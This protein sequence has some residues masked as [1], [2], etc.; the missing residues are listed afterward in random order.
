MLYAPWD[1]RCKLFRSSFL[2]VAGLFKEINEIKFIAV[3][4]NYYKG[5]C[6]S[7]YKL[8]AFP[9]IFAQTQ[10]NQPIIFNQFLS[11][12]RLYRFF[13][14]KFFYFKIETRPIARIFSRGG[15]RGKFFCAE[16]IFDF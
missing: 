12:E 14:K 15:K 11:S 13:S 9:V 8:L 10:Y 6:R 3:N 7:M 16:F 4:C 1:F 5:R 2:Y